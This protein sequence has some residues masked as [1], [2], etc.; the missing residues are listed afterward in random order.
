MNVLQKKEIG[1]VKVL[2][3]SPVAFIPEWQGS[4]RRVGQIVSMMEE[5]GFDVSFLFV[6]RDDQS[7]ANDLAMTEKLKGSFTELADIKEAN[8]FRPW[9][10]QAKIASKLRFYR[11]CNIH[12]DAWYFAK[13]GQQV[14]EIVANE[15]IDIVVCEYPFYSKA[16]ACVPDVLKIIDMHDVF[17]DRY[18]E[19]LRNGKKP[20][21][22]YS[23]SPAGEKKAISRADIVLAIQEGDAAVFRS[24]GRTNV[25]TLSYAPIPGNKIKRDKASKLKICFLGT[26]NTFNK[27]ALE[28]YL[29]SIHPPLLTVGIDYE[30]I[31]IGDVCE[32]FR[33]HEI[34]GNIRL[35]GR[36]DDLE[37]ELSQCDA[38]V[39]PLSSGTGLPIKVLDALACGLHVLAT[40]AGARGLPIRD[41]LSA[42][43]ICN[44]TQEWVDAIQTLAQRK[45]DGIDLTIEALGDLARIQKDID[46]SKQNLYE[47]LL[48]RLP[49]I[50]GELTRV[51]FADN[52]GVSRD[53][54]YCPRNAG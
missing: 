10:L 52:S 12:P 43:R 14:K 16:F 46:A 53:A 30:L 42:V 40:T 48:A 38:L 28:C 34:E 5:F 33:N 29:R 31:V 37:Q 15:N 44:E 32:T 9:F 19:F 13:I 49:R 22:W 39:N 27:S 24:Y 50:G 45:H 36:V 51:K 18:K 3:V 4:R 41:S 26:G 23:V 6:R 47:M 1:S 7:D 20:A 8:F 21:P 54:E 11:Y 35:L 25:L 2:I 17:A